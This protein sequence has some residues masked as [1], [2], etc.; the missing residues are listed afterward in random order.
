MGYFPVRYDFKVVIYERKMFI[1]LATGLHEPLS[2]SK[3]FFLSFNSASLFM[4][5]FELNLKSFLIKAHSH[6]MH[7]MR[8]AVADG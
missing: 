3:P 2:A 8:Q 1:R 7:L 4:I 5:A 6:E